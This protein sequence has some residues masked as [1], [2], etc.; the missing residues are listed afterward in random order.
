MPTAEG[1]A[2][3]SASLEYKTMP[4]REGYSILSKQTLEP[5]AGGVGVQAGCL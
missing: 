5:G 3:R 1:D 2:V 4:Q